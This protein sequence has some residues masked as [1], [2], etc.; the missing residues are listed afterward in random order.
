MFQ[1]PFNRIASC[2]RPKVWTYTVCAVGKVMPSGSHPTCSTYTSDVFWSREIVR[3]LMSQVQAAKCNVPGVLS[4]VV[5][6]LLW[7][8]TETKR[9]FQT[10]IWTKQLA[11]TSIYNVIVREKWNILVIELTGYLCTSCIW[12]QV[13][14]L[15]FHLAALWRCLWRTKKRVL[16]LFTR[17]IENWEDHKIV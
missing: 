3:S 12:C 17:S 15:T 6:I 14:K 9:M 16:S 11:I 10:F 2:Y 4:T 1:N 7:Q 13:N 8:H 5:I